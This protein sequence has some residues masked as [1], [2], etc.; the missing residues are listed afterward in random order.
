M[1]KLLRN[2]E[3]KIFSDASLLTTGKHCATFKLTIS[4]LT[5]VDTELE[6]M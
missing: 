4:V 1:G 5:S 2:K 6:I 3:T